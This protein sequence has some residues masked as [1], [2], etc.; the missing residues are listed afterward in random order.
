M[1]K[2][3]LLLAVALMGGVV[4]AQNDSTAVGRKVAIEQE[5][6]EL[7]STTEREQARPKVKK[8]GVVLSG[9][10]APRNHTSS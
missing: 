3:L 6:S 2:I 8:V 9:G 10:G 5:K 1:K 7:A 4:S